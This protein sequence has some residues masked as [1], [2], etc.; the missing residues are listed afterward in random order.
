VVKSIAVDKVGNLVV[1]GD[2]QGSISFGGD[3]LTTA[4]SL[5]VFIAKLAYP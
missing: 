2:L 3:Q 1:A 4:G 5:D